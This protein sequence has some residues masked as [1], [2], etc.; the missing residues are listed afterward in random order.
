MS[1]WDS[2]TKVIS[3]TAKSTITGRIISALLAA[4][5]DAK[6]AERL[7]L[8]KLDRDIRLLREG[9]FYSGLQELEAAE[10]EEDNPL[11]Q[12]RLI[13]SA[14]RFFVEARGIAGYPPADLVWAS[15]CELH[16]GL[17]WRAMNRFEQAQ[18][19]LYEAHRLGVEAIEAM[20][21]STVHPDNNPLF[22]TKAA[23]WAT[24]ALIAM[25]AGLF[26]FVW[27]ATRITISGN[28][29]VRWKNRLTL[30]PRI[31]RLSGIWP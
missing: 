31:L 2:V 23:A 9:P 17:C 28:L 10:R 22:K 5:I 13:E 1:G 26:G 30:I 3:D 12:G 18:H 8:E 16:I 6:S 7:L 14:R 24:F 19:R 15:L 20:A 4:I 29:G 11:E 25:T 21:E 27:G